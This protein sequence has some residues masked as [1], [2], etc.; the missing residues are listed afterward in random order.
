MD[1]L[2]APSPRERI[3]ALVTLG[4]PKFLVYS[5]VLVSLGSAC[6]ARAG[7][8]TTV[9]AWLRALA[10]VWTT[11]LMTHYANE[12]FD[13][14]ADRANRGAGAW[15]GGSGVLVSGR[16]SPDHAIGAASV[17]LMMGAL[18]QCLSLPADARWLGFFGIFLGWFYTAPP[19]R[20][21]YHGLGEL[22]V[23]TVLTVLTPAFA[24]VVQGGT[25]ADLPWVALVPLFFI[26]FVRMNLM[27]LADH[28]GDAQ[29]GK[30]TTVVRIGPVRVRRLH[31]VGQ[32]AALLWTALAF[33]FAGLGR[34]AALGIGLAAPLGV[35]QAVRVLR[36]PGDA[37]S[38]SSDSAAFW[39]TTHAALSI[40]GVQLA[41]LADLEHPH[42]VLWF[43]P[44]LFGAALGFQ[45]WERP[46]SR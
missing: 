42:V 16:L 29:V 26:Q 2:F 17:L 7:H 37:G 22:T 34:G 28:D 25:V 35:W 23:S 11:H 45:L 6:A 10:M 8:P 20:L 9:G 21:N 44:V 30:G 19:L 13:L 32:A 43:A 31:A 5:A 46:W 14:E 18:A 39:A 3:L 40:L 41:V 24:C 27:N 15:T 36:A 38:P 4:R 12:F 1:Q 33:A